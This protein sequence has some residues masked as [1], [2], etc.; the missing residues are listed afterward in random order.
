MKPSVIGLNT[1][2]VCGTLSS[3]PR[4]LELASG[5]RLIR[6]EVTVRSDGAPAA[7]SVPVAWFDPP[8]GPALSAG[9]G[10]VVTGRVR[11]RWFGGG[12]GARS[13]T[14]VVAT[15]VVP[16]SRRASA[17]KAIAAALDEVGTAL[18]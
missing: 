14:E 13:A 3:D 4:E 5:S 18:R 8:S 2:V 16:L 15:R 7:E 12:E 6:L 9:D 10:V 11:R 17:H 1:A